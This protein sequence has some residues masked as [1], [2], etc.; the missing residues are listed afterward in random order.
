[1]EQ[2]PGAVNWAAHNAEP[3]AGMVRLWSWEAIAHGAEFV[4][5]FRWRQAPFAQEQMHAGL[6]RPDNQPAIA[7]A[8]VQA[9]SREL[10]RLEL[11]DVTPASVALVFD[12]AAC[13]GIA[14][15]PQ[16]ASYSTLA[17]AL[18]WYS[19]A[20]GLGLDVDIVAPGSSLEGYALVLLPCQP[21]VDAKLLEQLKASSAQMVFGPR[22]GSK[23]EELTISDQLAPGPLQAFINLQI[24]SVDAVR[25]GV[26][27]AVEGGD[28]SDP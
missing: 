11:P 6:R 20:R 15:Q 1:M 27:I 24:I 16:Q 21:N 23:T 12:Y 28:A 17:T 5:W 4:S 2:Q 19:A 13:W 7:S 25:D 8:E 3:L 22:T 14:V 18:A 10:E 9:L 26:T